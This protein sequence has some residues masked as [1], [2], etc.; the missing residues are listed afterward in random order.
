MLS[1]FN[2]RSAARR[3]AMKSEYQFQNID[4]PGM[5]SPDRRLVCPKCREILCRADI[6]SYPFCPFCNHG[7]GMN[8]ALEDFILEPLVDDWMRRQP[9][10][11]AQET[12]FPVPER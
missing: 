9:G 8:A 10:F 1:I 11:K 3:G 6:E 4:H 7:F 5:I 2:M 12:P